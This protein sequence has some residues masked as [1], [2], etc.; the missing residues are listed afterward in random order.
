[1]LVVAVTFH[2]ELYIILQVDKSYKHITSIWQ[3]KTNAFG[4]SKA[5]VRMAGNSYI[6]S[7]LIHVNWW[8]IANAHFEQSWA[9]KS[10][11]P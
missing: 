1:M 6:G 5:H 10:E 7:H 2:D 9:R 11:L 4:S 3:I 8:Q